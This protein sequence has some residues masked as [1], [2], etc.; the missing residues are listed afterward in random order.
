MSEQNEAKYQLVTEN[1]EIKSSSRG[2]TG[3]GTATYQNND[4]YEGDFLDGKREGRGIY[5]YFEKGDKYEGQWEDNARHGIGKMVY[6]NIGEYHGYWENGK[7]HGEGVFTYQK[8]GD[9]YSGWWRFGE[10]EG[11]GTYVFKETGMKLVGTW[12]KCQMKT[13]QWIYPNG[14]YWKGNFENNKPT[15]KGTWYFKNGNTLEGEFSQVE[16][17]VDPD[18]EIPEEEEGAP[19]KKDLV[20]QSATNIAESAHQVNSVEQ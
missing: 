2:Y 13:G 7:R 9:V 18:A 14:L 8:T 3:Q 10:K 6:N 17:V 12:E 11:H 5:R 15:G 19:K 4:I 16:P 20:W 1:R